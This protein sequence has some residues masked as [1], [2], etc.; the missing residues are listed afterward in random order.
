MTIHHHRSSLFASTAL[1]GVARLARLGLATG[2]LG[3][4]GA[5]W[6]QDL[7]SGGVV[8]AGAATIAT[9]ATTVTVTQSSKAAA[10]DWTSFNIGTGKGVRFDQPDASSVTLNRVTGG[11][12]SV[13]L[14]NLTANGRVFLVNA[15]GVLFGRGA[16]VDVGGLVASTLD[17]SNAD[18]MA[19]RYSFSGS[20]GAAVLNRGTLTA[21]DGGFVALLGANVSN[22]GVI[23][24]RLGTVALAAGQGVTLDVAGDGLLNVAVD[25]G[26]MAALV[27]NGGLIRADG[28]QVMLTGQAAGQLLRTV[29]NNTG[30]IEARTIASRSGRIMLLGDMQG[31]TTNVAGVLDA[32]APGGG[33]GGFVETSAAR[34]NIADGVRVTTT[35][36]GGATGTWL[37]DPAD[38]IIAA[39]GG[40]ISGATLAAQLVTSSVTISTMTPDATGGNGD[41]FVDDAVAWS[42]SGAPTT[43]TLNGFRDININAAIT[44]TNGNV[45]AC[46]G[47]DVNVNA[48]ITTTNGSV[49]LN[50]GRD[51]HV[52]HAITTVDGNIA[53]CA[54]HDVHIDAAVT[55]T[56]GSTIPAQSLG[57]PVGLTLIAGGDG[58]GAGTIVF[59]PLAPPVT[60]TVAPVTI[61]YNPASY[62]APTDFSTRFVLTEGASL[63]QRMLVFPNGDKVF[64]GKVGTVLAGFNTT[65]AGTPGGISLVA[66][67][68]ATASFNDPAV[69]AGGGISYTGYTLA[70]P[71]ADSYAL[72]GSC[73]V[74]AFATFGTITPAPVVVPP[75]VVP[76]V[77][78]PPVVVPAPPVV[79]VPP[80]VVPPVV[81]PPVE[82]PPTTVPP[83]V[84]PGTPVPVTPVPVTPVAVP[85]VV[86]PPVAVVPPV[87]VPTPPVVVPPVTIPPAVLPVTVAPG[88][89]SQPPAPLYTAVLTGVLTPATAVASVP[90]LTVNGIG[91]AMPLVQQAWITRPTV[92]QAAQDRPVGRSDEQPRGNAFLPAPAVPV[93]PRKQARN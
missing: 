14:G 44:A 63:T 46:C 30:V 22:E 73:C 79:V 93:Y 43:L 47:R 16:Q 67:P 20:S 76:P 12:A 23:V 24:A 26:A 55:L 77:I 57:L 36:T 13:I 19:G 51:V 85:P 4:G 81:V 70:G 48:P 54:G 10:I 53:L 87:V 75:V 84:A 18:F 61:N 2:L 64:D 89:A 45:V 88:V 49:L 33:D 27:E 40:N 50:A 86:T 74:A 80:V 91:V 60:V 37:I 9:G 35:A 69:G 25:R 90:R 41:I 1:A 66:G 31:G 56:R 21:A 71:G 6:A 5:A 42:A 92:Q 28:G 15:N 38:F 8:A 78:V 72:A 82:T 62:A 11:D 59:A 34:V 3:F 58:T 52:F 39:T 83:V 17:I 32:S 65:A 7:P 29:V 68:N